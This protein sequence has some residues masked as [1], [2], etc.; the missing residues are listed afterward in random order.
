MYLQT[1]LDT[2]YR[3][4]S[5]WGIKDIFKK[6]G[7]NLS[8]ALTGEQSSVQPTPSAPAPSLLQK[9]GLPLALVGG[10]GALYFLVLRK[11]KGRR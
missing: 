7:I 3:A 11:K 10:A 9:Y 4:T 5:G 2:H 8:K 1:G 6:A